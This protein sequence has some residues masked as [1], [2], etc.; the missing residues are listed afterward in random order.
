MGSHKGRKLTGG[1]HICLYYGF[2]LA[3]VNRNGIDKG[4]DKNAIF[5]YM[6]D[7]I[8]ADFFFTMKGK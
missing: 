2:V 7:R 5:L 8:V 4:D 6:R 1:N 3:N